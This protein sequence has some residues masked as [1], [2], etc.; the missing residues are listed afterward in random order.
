MTG[1]L[2]CK[3]ILKFLWYSFRIYTAGKSLGNDHM[4]SVGVEEKKECHQWH[5]KVIHR[6]PLL[7]S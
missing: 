3:K 2:W 6:L 5:G 1:G 7:S 4:S